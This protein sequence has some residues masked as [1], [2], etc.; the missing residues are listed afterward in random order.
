MTFV[1]ARRNRFYN[2]LV[3]TLWTPQDRAGL[4]ARFDRLS[5]DARPLWGS[6][7]APRMV[8]H[9]T[10]A[11]RAGLGEVPVAPVRGP[12][13]VWPLN[14]LIVYWLPWPKGAPTAPELTA[15]VPTHWGD[16]LSALR[17][18]IERFARRDVA[19]RWPEHAAFGRLDGPAWGR[20]QYRHLDHHLRQFGV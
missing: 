18:A 7:D 11:L 9:V 19:G 10:D 8:T 20:L 13:R 3:Q 17:D 16:E 5:P 2:A 4:L 15:R 6:L 1:M 14:A 12:L